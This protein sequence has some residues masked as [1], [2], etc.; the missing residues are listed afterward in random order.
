MRSKQIVDH[1]TMKLAF[2]FD[3]L[4]IAHHHPQHGHEVGHQ[5]ENN[6]VPFDVNII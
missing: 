6:V 3:Y 5:E 1:E 4:E 2:D